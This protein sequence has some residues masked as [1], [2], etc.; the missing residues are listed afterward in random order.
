MLAPPVVDPRIE[1][2]YTFQ[3]PDKTSG[4]SKEPLTTI[5]AACACTDSNN[6]ANKIIFSCHFP[7]LK[8]A[9]QPYLFRIED[10]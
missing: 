10:L 1:G 5:F 9:A 6:D 2:E 3:F 4:F 7:L 8:N